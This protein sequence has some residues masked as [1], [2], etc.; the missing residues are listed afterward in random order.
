MGGATFMHGTWR[1]RSGVRSGGRGTRRDKAVQKG[2][3]SRFDLPLRFDSK[4]AALDEGEE[5]VVGG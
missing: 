2:P 4:D 5:K 3:A 1:S